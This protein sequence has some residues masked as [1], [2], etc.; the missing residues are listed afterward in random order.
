MNAMVS[1]I[2]SL[3]IVYSTIYSGTDQSKHQSSASLA[4]V[5]GIHRA[6][7]NSPHK[8]PV[9]RK[10]FPFH[11]VIMYF[12]TEQV[13]SQHL[14]LWWSISLTDTCGTR[15]RWL[16]YIGTLT[17]RPGQNSCLFTNIIL[18]MIWSMKLWVGHSQGSHTFQRTKF[19]TFSRLFPDHFCDFQ[20]RFLSYLIN[21]M[22]PRKGYKTQS[23]TKLISN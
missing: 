4:F 22:L 16:R 18:G 21:N 1:Q 6:P 10:M 15:E 11:E 13:I 3:T 17:L 9:T 14:N 20:D 7:V 2:T 5:W 12:D 19:K 8:R 23:K